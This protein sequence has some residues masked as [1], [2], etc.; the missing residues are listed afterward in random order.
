LTSNFLKQVKYF[1][2][3]VLGTFHLDEQTGKTTFDI[4]KIYK[5]DIEIKTI[6]LIVGGLDCYHPLWFN[7]GQELIIGLNKSPYQSHADS[8]VAQGC[9]TS[10]LY[11]KKDKITT[12]DKIHSL[13]AV[14]GQRI[15]LFTKTM[16]L[17]TLEKRLE[18]KHV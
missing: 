7:N 6:D 14:G 13:P 1:D 15:G 11:V 18:T 3:I 2:I 17:K 16:K 9:V 4:K 8:F 5:G 10:V 12:V